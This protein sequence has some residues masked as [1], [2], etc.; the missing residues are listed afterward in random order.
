M[1]EAGDLKR[2]VFGNGKLAFNSAWTQGFFAS[3]AEGLSYGL[4]QTA[5]GPCGEALGLGFTV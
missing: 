5:G 4:V 3:S 1:A 2:L